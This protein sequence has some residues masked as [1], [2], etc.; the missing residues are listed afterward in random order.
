MDI[1]DQGIA[2]FLRNGE[3]FLAISTKFFHNLAQGGIWSDDIHWYAF[4]V[5]F[6]FLL[7]QSGYMVL[8]LFIF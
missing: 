7:Y 3:F 5:L 1:S 2:L 6:I 8:F 4:F